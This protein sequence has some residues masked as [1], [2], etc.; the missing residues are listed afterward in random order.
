[1]DNGNATVKD[2]LEANAWIVPVLVGMLGGDVTITA[3][4]IA[5]FGEGMTLVIHDT[6]EGLR[7]VKMP[8]E[9]AAALASGST[10]TQ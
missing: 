8:V 10:E 3:E 9:H 6:M 2:F 7:F 1:M 5:E 4:N